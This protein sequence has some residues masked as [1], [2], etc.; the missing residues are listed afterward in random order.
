MKVVLQAIAFHLAASSL[1]L[2]LK[3]TGFAY[4]LKPERVRQILR[5]LP[6][7]FSTIAWHPQDTSLVESQNSRV[8]WSKSKRGQGFSQR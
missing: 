1:L 4:G 8:L 3:K 2:L 5:K 7:W 6:W